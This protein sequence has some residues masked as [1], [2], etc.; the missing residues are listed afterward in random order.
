MPMFLGH[1]ISKSKGLVDQQKVLC[2][3][4]EVIQKSSK[5]PVKSSSRPSYSMGNLKYG[6]QKCVS[7]D[8][9]KGYY[10]VLSVI[11]E[12]YEMI[13][14]L[15]HTDEETSCSFE[16]NIDKGDSD[17]R[18]QEYEIIDD[19]YHVDRE[20]SCCSIL[21]KEDSDLVQ[22]EADFLIGDLDLFEKESCNKQEV[23]VM[24]LLPE[25]LGIE[26]GDPT[27]DEKL[28]SCYSEANSKDF[29]KYS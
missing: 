9:S 20:E 12:E 4:K 28:L 11:S 17:V 13:G 7:E 8:I 15:L 6:A 3:R 5:S 24:Q 23:D 25:H 27:P 16:E 14:D 26:Y 10:E 1:I 21:T 2:S 18:G 22:H 19:F 29:M